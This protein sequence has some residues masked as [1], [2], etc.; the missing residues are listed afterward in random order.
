MPLKTHLIDHQEESQSASIQQPVI[1]Y[2]KY[3]HGQQ[4]RNVSEHL[5]SP[6]EQPGSQQ[7]V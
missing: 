5:K 4:C 3:T 7:G 6:E 2:K 1:K